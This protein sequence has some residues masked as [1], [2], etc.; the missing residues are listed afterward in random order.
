MDLN[1]TSARI[2]WTN[3]AS[4]GEP[5]LYYTIETRTHWTQEWHT[6]AE[7]I[8]AIV[9]YSHAYCISENIVINIVVV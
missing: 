6:V 3:G 1:S 8:T 4:N 9:S 2:Q 7:N 5:V